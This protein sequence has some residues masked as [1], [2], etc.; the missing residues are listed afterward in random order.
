MGA[1]PDTFWLLQGRASKVFDKF[2]AW[3]HD[4]QWG[5]RPYG[6]IF[7]AFY[8]LMMIITICLLS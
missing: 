7:D 1:V 2:L 6:W 8:A 5:E 3:A 4:I